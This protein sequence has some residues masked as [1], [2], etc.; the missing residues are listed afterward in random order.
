[1]LPI[2]LGA[3]ISV[4]PATLTLQIGGLTFGKVTASAAS[5]HVAIGTSTCFATNPSSRD[6]LNVYSRTSSESGKFTTL[7]IHVKAQRPGKCEIKFQSDSNFQAVNVNVKP[8][9]P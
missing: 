9:E 4:S 5:K 7:T 8:E 3:V 6:I 1:M 2:L